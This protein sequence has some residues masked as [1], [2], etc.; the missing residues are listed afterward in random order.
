MT[1]KLTTLSTASEGVAPVAPSPKPQT[2]EER[3]LAALGLL[4]GPLPRA[5]ARWL[6]R[7]Y[8]YLAAHLCL[9]F[10]AR[11]AEDSGVLRPWTSSVTVVALLWPCDAHAQDGTGLKCKALRGAE[12]T[13][14]PLV[15]LEVEGDDP[16]AQL[17]ED[18]WYWFW[19]WQFDPKI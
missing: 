13:E 3:I 9:P 14:I 12:A 8:D 15:D 18:Y 19:N 4:R 1:D 2:Q 6:V 11:C 10:E 7:Y 17:I 5:V 16:N